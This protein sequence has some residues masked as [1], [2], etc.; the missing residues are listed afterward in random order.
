MFEYKIQAGNNPTQSKKLPYLRI[1]DCLFHLDQTIWRKLKALGLQNRKNN[2]ETFRRGTSS[3]KLN[4]E[5]AGFS[6]ML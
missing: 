1:R 6:R 2:D 3:I 4:I 5:P